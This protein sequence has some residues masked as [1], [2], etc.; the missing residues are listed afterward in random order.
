MIGTL[1]AGG[2][3]AVR[4]ETRALPIA[5]GPSGHTSAGARV[6]EMGRPAVRLGVPA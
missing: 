6:I 4:R 5:G 2:R 3:P 1:I